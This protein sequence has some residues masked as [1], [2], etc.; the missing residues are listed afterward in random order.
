MFDKDRFESKEAMIA[1][2]E[3]INP[4]GLFEFASCSN[5]LLA[6]W[7]YECGEACPNVGGDI[8]FSYIDASKQNDSRDL[9]CE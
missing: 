5:C 9:I 2:L 1:W 8:Y 3:T 4:I 6:T 7:Q